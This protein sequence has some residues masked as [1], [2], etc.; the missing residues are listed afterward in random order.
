MAA[1]TLYHALLLAVPDLPLVEM[2]IADFRDLF[3]CLTAP[4]GKGGYGLK[5][6]GAT[7]FDY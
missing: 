4:K 7:M 6:R 5:V 1:F 3:Q 2:R